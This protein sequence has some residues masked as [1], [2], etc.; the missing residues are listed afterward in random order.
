MLASQ[1]IIKGNVQSW[2]EK[3]R[4]RVGNCV[5]YLGENYQNATG[6]NTQ[7]DLLLDWIK[8]SFLLPTKTS[9]LI[10]DGDDGNKFISLLDL[11]SNLILYP[12]NVASDIGG[13]FKM[14]TGIHEPDYNT[15]AVDFSTG[16]VTTTDQLVGSLATASN[17]INGNPGVFNITMIGNITRTVGSGTASFYFKAYKRDSGGTETLVATSST[18][19]PV[20]DTGYVEFNTTGLWDD[21]SFVSTDRIVI[22]FYANRI[23]EGSNPTFTFQFGGV[24]PVRVLV[25]IPLTVVPSGAIPLPGTEVGSPITGTLVQRNDADIYQK[26]EDDN[27]DTEIGRIFNGGSY[28]VV[29]TSQV[30]GG[31]STSFQNGKIETTSLAFDIDTE[32]TANGGRGMSSAQDYSANITDLDYVQKIYADSL[33]ENLMPYVISAPGSTIQFDRPYEYGSFASPTGVSPLND[34]LLNARKGVV[35][36]IYHNALT[37]PTYPIGWVKLFGDYTPSETNIIFCVWAGGDRVEYW[38]IKATP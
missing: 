28:G 5:V 36:K 18:T 7:P 32:I 19:V 10:N 9:D 15:T 21:G 11:P 38:I 6:K 24:A 20:I 33:V 13:Y 29:Y 25:P 16:S 1:G 17:L 12:T 31:D 8:I 3:K 23:A 37:E 2:N 34:Y 30:D 22:K 35:Q 14:V 27:S 26:F 4:Y